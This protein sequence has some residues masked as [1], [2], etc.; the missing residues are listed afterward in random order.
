MLGEEINEMDQNRLRIQRFISFCGKTVLKNSPKISKFISILESLQLPN[1][2]S[3]II[4]DDVVYKLRVFIINFLSGCPVLTNWIYEKVI[5]N[6]DEKKGL[7]DYARLFQETKSC[8]MG[9]YLL[10][11]NIALFGIVGGEEEGEVGEIVAGNESDNNG[12]LIQENLL[13]KFE[14]LEDYYKFFRYVEFFICLL[15]S[16]ISFIYQK[17]HEGVIKEEEEK[18]TD[19][20][21]DEDKENKKK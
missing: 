20:E 4:I 6:K 17:V 12:Q 14:N 16:D 2:Q 15:D 21:D 13:K 5:M 9:F 18:H 11:L 19:S 3:D 10:H 1:P 8:E 7:D